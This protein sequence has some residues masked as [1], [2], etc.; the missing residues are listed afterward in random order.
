MAGSAP[1]P[2]ALGLMCGTSMDGVDAALL[3]SDGDRVA[4][5]L[6]ANGHPDPLGPVFSRPFTPAERSLLRAA[7]EAAKSLTRRDERPGILAEAE[8]LVTRANAEAALGLLA[9]AGVRPDAVAVA[10]FHGQT[11]LHRPAERLTVQLGD[12][13]GL[14]DALR[15]PVVYD[16]RAGDVATGGEGAPL[17]P[18]FHRALARATGHQPPL[19]IL[20]VGGVANV[21]LIEEGDDLL[22]FDTGPGNALLDDLMGEREGASCDRDGAAAARGR[23]DEALLT[24]LLS[25]PYF[26]RP[27][28]KSL[29]RD[30]FSH[31]VLGPLPTADAAATLTAF[32]A[33]SAARALDW[34]TTRPRCWI[35]GGGGARN[36]TLMRRLAEALGPEVELRGA[37][38]LGWSADHLEA[39]AFAYLAARS[40]ANLPLTYPRT[41]G[42]PA[43]LPG[44]V[45]ARPR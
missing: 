36:P 2:W 1:L 6:G 35:V 32:T 3:R 12:G 38:A 23:P 5:D 26:G 19:A 44:G 11:V 42:V 7:K 41:T 8:E 34:T 30:A 29:D 37:D 16:L 25:H 9:A 15:I 10:G 39:Q 28:P 17:V 18:V 13:Q 24:W 43:P 4:V 21:T 27:P 22:A 31:R 20:N 45:L 14:A 40:L 33:R